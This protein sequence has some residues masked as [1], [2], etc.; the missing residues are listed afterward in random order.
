[1]GGV[2][3]KA[4]LIDILQG[5]LS[6]PT[7]VQ[8]SDLGTKINAAISSITVR[9]TLHCAKL[10][11]KWASMMDKLNTAGKK[12]KSFFCHEFVYCA[13]SFGLSEY[14]QFLCNQC[15][16]N[17]TLHSL[18]RRRM[19]HRSNPSPSLSCDLYEISI[20]YLSVF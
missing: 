10:C 15:V 3:S 6:D 13:S 9:L 18:C 5:S 17:H 7:A 1:M 19:L 8:P 11:T 20:H 4:S 2:A 14:L 12:L 16:V